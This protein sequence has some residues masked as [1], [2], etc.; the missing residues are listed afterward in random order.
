[1]TDP[2]ELPELARAVHYQLGKQ[3]DTTIYDITAN[4]IEVFEKE[5]HEVHHTEVGDDIIMIEGEPYW[6]TW[7]LEPVDPME[8]QKMANAANN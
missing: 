6:V 3:L 4:I 1:M 5:G 7:N 2:R 8:F